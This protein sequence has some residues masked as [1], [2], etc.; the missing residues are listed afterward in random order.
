[1]LGQGGLGGEQ[2]F[3]LGGTAAGAGGEAGDIDGD[4]ALG[5]LGDQDLDPAGGGAGVRAGL[6][7]L[8]PV[9]RF[10]PGQHRVLF[11]VA[12]E[13]EACAADAFEVIKKRHVAPGAVERTV[14]TA[15]RGKPGRPRRGLNQSKMVALSAATA[16][17]REVDRGIG[18]VEPPKL[19]VV[20]VAQNG[21]LAALATTFVLEGRGQGSA[22]VL[23]HQSGQG[24]RCRQDRLIKGE[25]SFQAGGDV[26]GQDRA[27]PAFEKGD[28]LA[29]A[30][31]GGGTHR[32]QSDGPGV[33]GIGG[34]GDGVPEVLFILRHG[35]L[36]GG[37]W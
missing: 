32:R 23:V 19:R 10:R 31:A 13:G 11:G 22:P 2:R 33:D 17:E 7:Q 26:P 16:A 34:A 37:G 20:G 9:S 21:V 6:G 25:P 4:G 3:S 27:P 8:A 29:L 1:M 30:A 28:G 12:A 35:G 15:G 36:R 24:V 18:P 5:R 14:G